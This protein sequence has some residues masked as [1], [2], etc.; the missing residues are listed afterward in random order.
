M[1]EV[2]QDARL[3]RTP[4]MVMGATMLLALMFASIGAQPD[5]T[6]DGMGMQIFQG[7]F[8]LGFFLAAL[9]GPALSANSI[10]AEREGR[11]WE[12]LLL[13]GMTPQEITRGKFLAAAT[14]LGV[15]V[16]ALAPVA[17][18]CFLFGGVHWLEVLIA[19]FYLFWI[20]MLWVG[21]G[22]AM[23]SRLVQARGAIVVTLVASLPM[24]G[25][26]FGVFGFGFGSLAHSLWPQVPREIPVWL[27]VA[28][29]RGELDLWYVLLLGLGPLALFGLPLWGLYEATLANLTEPTD[30]RST[31]LKRWFVGFLVAAA[32]S[33]VTA[34]GAVPSSE[35]SS[36]TGT[37]VG[38]T[39]VAGLLGILILLPDPLGASRRVQKRWEIDAAGPI[40]RWLGPGLIR[41][42]VL[43]LAG[44]LLVI[45]L[46]LG[47]VVVRGAFLHFDSV[48]RFTGYTVGFYVFCVGLTV[49]MRARS[50][51]ANTVRLLLLLLVTA[52]AAIP[53][54]V[55]FI[56]GVALF[57]NPEGAWVLA[58]PSPAFLVTFA[59]GINDTH[60]IVGWVAS[61]GWGAL[62]VLLFRIGRQ[63]IDGILL[64]FEDRL[65]ASD[66]MYREEDEALAAAAAEAAQPDGIS[67]PTPEAAAPTTG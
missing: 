65:K 32:I 22:L 48:L 29:V 25:V 27:P 50:N 49:Y 11:T 14:N 64:D 31:G 67:E 46:Q 52:I 58:A 2:R 66:R 18:M 38:L 13:T 24:A 47:V 1:R 51:N 55:A 57:Q 16:V 26:A 23:S 4:W 53:P 41:T 30:D 61:V 39:S 42:M 62:G 63:K 28:Y 21:F 10:A 36:V 12:A 8:S 37:A 54:I 9:A 44:P 20:T 56:V 15:Y 43:A 5:D 40:R 33:S 45:A 35:V 34:I 19:F 7:F 60:E 59:K 3:A 17:A 6:Q